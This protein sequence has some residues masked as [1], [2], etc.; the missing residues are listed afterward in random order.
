MRAEPDADDVHKMTVIINIQVI[1]RFI[2]EED[3]YT[4][5][6]LFKMS[7]NELQ[8]IQ[9]NLIIKYNKALCQNLIYQKST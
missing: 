1:L 4:F 2:K 6:D 7:Y 3:K 8:E 5:E 9:K